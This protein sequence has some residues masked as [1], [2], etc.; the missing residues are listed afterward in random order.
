MET[1]RQKVF[2]TRAAVTGNARSPIVECFD[3]G[4]IGT[5]VFD[6]RSRRQES[7]SA[8]G[9]SSADKYSGAGPCWQQKASTALR[10]SLRNS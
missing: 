6:D 5:A 1:V 8:T 4:M 10:Y 7:A 3:P 2:Q 9:V